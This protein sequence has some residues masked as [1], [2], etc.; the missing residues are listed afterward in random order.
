MTVSVGGRS[1]SSDQIAE[2]DLR[3]MLFGEEDDTNVLAV[4]GQIRDFTSD[5]PS[6]VTAS[7]VYAALFALLFTEALIESGRASRVTKVQVSPPGPL[8]RNL[9]LEW[10]GHNNRGDEPTSR[11]LSGILPVRR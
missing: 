3:R 2:R 10:V 1:Y 6:W 7:D 4:G 5:L 9:S 8:G 11:T